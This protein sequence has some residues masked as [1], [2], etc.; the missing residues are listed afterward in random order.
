MPPPMIAMRA[1][2]FIEVLL[3]SEKSPHYRALAGNS[4]SC[5]Q[6][7]HSLYLAPTGHVIPACPATATSTIAPA[8]LARGFRTK[9]TE[10]PIPHD[11]FARQ[12]ETPDSLFYAQP[13]LVYHI[14]E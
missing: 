6:A 10:S 2:L 12:D 11:A 1:F 5:V 9:M 14:D 7:C 4:A 13:R 8:S 3:A